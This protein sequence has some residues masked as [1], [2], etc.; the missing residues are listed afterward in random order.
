[1]HVLVIPS[2]YP[3]AERPAAGVFFQDQARVLHKAGMRVGVVAPIQRSIRTLAH[4]HVL[5]YG[6]QTQFC[7]EEGI[8]TFRSLGWAVPKLPR[9]SRQI[10][11]WQARRL[12]DQ[13]VKRFGKPDIIHAHA[14]LWGGVAALEAS[15]RLGVPF[16]VTEH[17]SAYARG[18]IKPWEETFIKRVLQRAAARVAVS[19]SLARLMAPYAM[20]MPI[21]IVPNVV[22]TEFF[23]PPPL[24]RPSRP[25]IFLS[26]ALLT[27]K[28]GIDV[29]I[30][31]FAAKF[32]GYADVELWIGGDGPQRSDL[33]R[34]VHSL[35]IKSQVR[36]LGLLSREQVRE[37]MWR[38]NV[39]VLPSY[40]ETFGVV[41]IEALATGLPVIAT[42]CG[43]PE[44]FVTR[45]VGRLVSPGSVSG[46]AECMEFM[47]EDACMRFDGHKISRLAHS[48]FG[49]SA[50]S[51]RLEE[52]YRE[53]SGS[54][55]V[56]R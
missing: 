6:F 39:F 1:M 9:V 31:A 8:P 33:E 42:S 36:F 44:E 47:F 41:L 20:G 16:L 4:G 51:S 50:V 2:W 53:V 35:D 23:S 32:K 48:R 28:K 12:V 30:K 38:A 15:Q 52:I 27:P 25:F 29:L 40:V 21:E 37:A 11:L 17:S 55:K 54:F 49:Y 22:D 14:V 46:L 10:W 5:K 7:E 3:T 26:V 24:P 43:G 34:L 18:L 56:K 45:E 13:Y 19:Q